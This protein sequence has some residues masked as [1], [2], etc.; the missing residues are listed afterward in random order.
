MEAHTPDKNQ[1]NPEDVESCGFLGDNNLR[2]TNVGLDPSGFCRQHQLVLLHPVYTETGEHLRQDV[3]EFWT[4]N[5]FF[6]LVE[7]GLFSVFLTLDRIGPDDGVVGRAARFLPLLGGVIAVVW[8][9]IAAWSVYWIARWR[10]AFTAIEGELDPWR[11]H[12]M[13]GR[14]IQR[15]SAV[16]GVAV[17]IP[18]LFIIGWVYVSWR[19]PFAMSAGFVILLIALV[20]TTLLFLWTMGQDQAPVED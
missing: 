2:C 16:Q 19:T 13:A 11:S 14:G 9:W 5:N 10:E 7:G 6:L 3:R 15:R 17:S 8:L 20:A 12:R 1:G 4:R 18:V